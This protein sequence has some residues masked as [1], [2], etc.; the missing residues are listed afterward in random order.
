M[1]YFTKSMGVLV[2]AGLTV[3]SLS[4]AAFAASIVSFNGPAG[5]AYIGRFIK[6]IK[7]TAELKGYD[8]ISSI[9]QSKTNR[10]SK[11]CPL[12][13]CLMYSSGGL[14][15]RLLALDRCALWLKPAFL[16]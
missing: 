3:G 15:T 5:E 11:C 13:N 9:R 16:F 10:C 1:S 2:A 12:D 14:L 8:R 7:D 4:S 6:G